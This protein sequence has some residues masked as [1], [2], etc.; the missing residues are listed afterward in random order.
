[1][2]KGW[3]PERRAAQTERIRAQ[4]PWEKSTG[5]RSAAGK[6]RCRRNALKHGRYAAGARD[7]DHAIRLNREFRRLAADL[8]T[9]DRLL[10]T[11]RKRTEAASLPDQTVSVA[12]DFLL[13]RTETPDGT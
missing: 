12:S 10:P 5:P 2:T 13:Q 8:L 3:T 11:L 4:K 1:M 7:L 6:D 9:R